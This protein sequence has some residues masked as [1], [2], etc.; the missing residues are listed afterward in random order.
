MTRT[1]AEANPRPKTSAAP[2]GV[3]AARRHDRW[4]W[5]VVAVGSVMYLIHYLGGRALWLDE[6][7]IALNIRHLSFAELAGKLDYNQMAPVGWS[8]IEKVAFNLFGD[9]EY[10]L[11][12]WPVLA[13]IAAL[14]LFRQL[15]FRLLS[16]FG[17]LAAV[18]LFAGNGALVRYAAEVK[19]YSTDVMLSVAAMLTAA[20]IITDGPVKAWRF[21]AF[22]LVGLAA[23]FLSFSAVYVLAAAGTVVFLH[24]ALQKRWALTAATAAVGLAWLIVFGVL[25]LKVYMPQ[26]AGSDLVEGAAADFFEE[27]SYAP[28]APRGFDNLVWYARWTEDLLD[29]LFR[30]EAWFPAAILIG[31]GILARLRQWRFLALAL[32]PLGLG[33]IGSGLELYPLYERLV[34]FAAPGLLLV[35]GAGVAWFVGVSRGSIVAPAAM[36]VMVLLGSAPYLVGGLLKARPSFAQHNVHPGLERLKA[37][38]KPEDIIYVTNSTIPA[39]LLYRQA[40]GLQGRRWIAGKTP[41]YSWDCFINEMPRT[42]HPQRIWVL[43]SANLTEDWKARPSAT[44]LAEDGRSGQFKLDVAAPSAWLYHAETAA[45]PGQP[46]SLGAPCSVDP[47]ANRFDVPKRLGQ[48]AGA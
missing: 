5:A 2:R 31:V 7:M 36:V 27:T 14:V 39:Y 48:R 30:R 29:F 15:A 24:F 21:A 20:M 26:L 45:L 12:L 44:D 10:G 43:F 11:R 1:F 32:A 16:G 9:L 8:Y 40:Y 38:A 4:S 41:L 34:L 47:L 17:A 23:V 46:L 28:L 37:Q 25:M 18:V 19:P 33:L 42:A 35:A 13:A 6:A 22:A 3:G